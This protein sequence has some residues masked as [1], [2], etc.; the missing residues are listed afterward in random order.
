MPSKYNNYYLDSVDIIK[1][2][3][4]RK[5]TLLIH[6]CCGP[7]ACYPLIF[8]AEHF[9]VTI[10]YTNSNIFPREEFDHRLS[11]LKELLEDL[12][13]DRGIEIKLIVA[14]YDHDE[15]MK[16]LRPFKEAREGG[17]RCHI[18]YQKRMAEGYDYA[19]SHGYEYFTTVMTISREKD[20]KVLNAIG[21]ELAKS[22]QTKY[23]FSDFKKKDG[24]NKGVAIR[25]QYN[26]YY[27]DYCGCEYSFGRK[28]D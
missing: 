5:P 21:E 19:D 11:T 14:P 8:L 20:S 10:Y 23:F 18:C 22:H 28:R 15:Y 7:C 3:G 13:R 2:F 16:D 1:S 6:V 9:S 25:K 4:E 24:F 12:K 17:E 27:Q 26:L